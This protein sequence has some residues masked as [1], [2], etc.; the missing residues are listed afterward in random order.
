M[1]AT[2]ALATQAQGGSD[3]RRRAASA[4]RRIEIVAA[5]PIESEALA[6]GGAGP[7]MIVERHHDRN[8]SSSGL[9]KQREAE[10]HCVLHVQDVGRES[11]EYVRDSDAGP[12]VVP[13][14]L[15]SRPIA[16]LN[17][18]EESDA[19]GLLG[20]DLAGR[21]RGVDSREED[22]DVVSAGLTIREAI[23]VDF[24][25]RHLLRKVVVHRM[26]DSHLVSGAHGSEVTDSSSLPAQ[27]RESAI[28]ARNARSVGLM[29]LALAWFGALFFAHR[30]ILS[31]LP[32]LR[33]IDPIEAFFF[34]TSTTIPAL[35]FALFALV[36]VH[37]R[38][39]LA[40][41]IE[42]GS[43]FGA[44]ATGAMLALLGLAW[45]GW[46]RITEQIDLQVDSLVLLVAASGLMLGGLR[47]LER[48]AL[49]L[50]LLWLARPWP[51]MLT[52]HLH[53]WLQQATGTF[54]QLM[55]SPFAPIDRSG[56]LLFFNERVF[57]VIEGCSGLRLEITLITATLFYL[58]FV[59]RSRRQTLGVLL[60]ALA[61]GPLLNGLRVVSIMLNPT[62]EVAQVHSTQGLLFI[63]LG[64]ITIAL[65]DR[66][67]EPR[68]W[69][70]NRAESEADADPTEPKA[71]N[72]MPHRSRVPAATAA[73]AVV[74][75]GAAMLVSLYSPD[76]TAGSTTHDRWQLDRIGTRLGKWQRTG[77]LDLD[78]QFLGT[79]T[80]SDK[81]YWRFE[82]ENETGEA[83]LFVS[84]DDRR[85]R[86]KSSFTPKTRALGA[87]WQIEESTSIALALPPFE[88]ERMIQRRGNEREI[89]LHYRIGSRS[90]LDAS[91]RWWTA[92]DLADSAESPHLV[93][94]RL[95]VPINERNPA[96]A[97]AH[98]NELQA[99]L[100]P[101]LARAAPPLDQS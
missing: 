87:G 22:A 4:A 73:S 65:L 59:S 88:A 72:P 8:R 36:M 70:P 64:V 17:E 39:A 6:A 53:E 90:L 89:V 20:R 74:V 16:V 30:D 46:S 84:T 55:L 101:A 51:P 98:L 1:S 27:P 38:H 95:S 32:K 2:Q 12:R 7:P 19:A 54:A 40:D 97:L 23:R 42:S 80:F 11:I 21:A 41:A 31:F 37:R 13:S 18:R 9:A 15:E 91:L 48:L 78:T 43:R 33:G 85:R 10:I 47:L 75:A 14:L 60:L 69:P 34:D 79:A 83:A 44:R 24:H 96:R 50:A 93:T 62:A 63:S 67:L 3:E 29:A 66:F 81:L 25:A 52:M 82:R 76:S 61:I 94:V 56:H 68:C 26:Q 45:L 49:P 57:E 5:I 77:S 92:A 28:P 100:A 99:L 86:D 58:D 71:P 35:H